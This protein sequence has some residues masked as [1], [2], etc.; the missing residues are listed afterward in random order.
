MEEAC[1]VQYCCDP[2][3]NTSV[4]HSAK[5]KSLTTKIGLW[6]VPATSIPVPKR[7]KKIQISLESV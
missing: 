7:I 2:A 3:T 6:K 4:T 1:L 5:D